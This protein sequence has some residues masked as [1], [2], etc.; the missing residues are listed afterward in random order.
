LADTVVDTLP[1]TM[2]NHTA[3]GFVFNDAH[4]GTLL[5]AIKRATLLYS[6][7]DVWRQLQTNAMSR[8]FSWQNSAEQYLALYESIE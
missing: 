2:A 5:E 3:T 7:S 4:A 1:E 8:D 6:F